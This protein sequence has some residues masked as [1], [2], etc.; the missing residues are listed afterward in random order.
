MKQ[1]MNQPDAGLGNRVRPE[2]QLRTLR[3]LW[4]VF[5][6]TIGLFI[7]VA[8]VSGAGADAEVEGVPPMLYA[9][10]ALGLSS[11]VGSFVLKSSFY[12][13]AAERQSPPKLQEG[14]IIALALCETCVL[15]GVTALVATQSNYAYALFALGALGEAL[16]FPTRTQVLSAYYK[17]AG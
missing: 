17:P 15:F 3:I 7:L 10:G 8:V 11:V 6:I 4:V 1:P 9:F 16:H 14:L 5:L 2:A 13:R 12:S